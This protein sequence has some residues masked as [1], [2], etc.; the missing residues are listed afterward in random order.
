MD[1]LICMFNLMLQSAISNKSSWKKSNR[2]FAK[3]TGT[4]YF[5]G[6]PTESCIR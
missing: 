5:N 3:A 2:A 1:Y 6:I 4:H